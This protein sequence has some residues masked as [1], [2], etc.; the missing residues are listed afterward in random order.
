M[1]EIRDQELL[2]CDLDQTPELESLQIP[3]WFAQGI[4][5]LQGFIS[6]ELLIGDDTKPMGLCPIGMLTQRTPPRHSHAGRV[7]HFCCPGNAS[8]ERMRAYPGR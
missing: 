5:G 8:R 4:G 1:V 2:E 6:T 7:A 3:L